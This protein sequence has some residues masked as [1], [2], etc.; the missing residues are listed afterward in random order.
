MPPSPTVELRGPFLVRSPSGEVRIGTLADLRTAMATTFRGQPVEIFELSSGRYIAATALREV[1]SSTIRRVSEAP[2]PAEPTPP[3][4][5]QAAPPARPAVPPA[6]AGRAPVGPANPPSRPAGSPGRSS[7]SSSGWPVLAAPP[8]DSWSVPIEVLPPAPARPGGA[9]AQ[10]GAETD[11]GAARR[12]SDAGGRG[13]AG[14]AARTGTGSDR[15][16]ATGS[17]RRTTAEAAGQSAGRDGGGTSS[18]RRTTAAREVSGPHPG[19]AQPTSAPVDRPAPLEP[20]RRAGLGPSDPLTSTTARARRPASESPGPSIVVGAGARPTGSTAR[21]TARPGDPATAPARPSVSGRASA[22]PQRPSSRLH[23]AWVRDLDPGGAA[24][25][26]ADDDDDAAPEGSRA[27][28][29]ITVL[30]IVLAVAGAVLF[31]ARQSGMFAPDMTATASPPRAA[32]TAPAPPPAPSAAAGGDATTTPAEAVQSVRP[33]TAVTAPSKQGLQLWLPFTT[34]GQ[35]GADSS[36]RRVR[37]KVGGAVTVVDDAQRHGVAQFDGR[38]DIAFANPVHGAFTIACWLRTTQDQVVPAADA[39][40]AGWYQGIGLIDGEVDGIVS[41]FGLSL[42]EGR[43]AFG[44]GAPDTTLLSRGPAERR[45]LAPRGR[46]ARRARDAH[47]LHRRPPRRFAPRR[48]RA[49]R[50]DQAPDH[51][52]HPDRLQPLHRQARRGAHLRPRPGRRRGG[53]AGRF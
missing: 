3:A 22:T 8:A 9:A 11:S 6:S 29:V 14:D 28:R 25:G 40:H 17:A 32:H 16:I 15:S 35:P 36:G 53:D 19:S 52:L 5:W 1:V 41:D 23:P 4:T 43:C 10:D 39:D 31:W 48:A 27:V 38:S 37:T 33:G 51:R 44:S 21:L 12:L 42:I 13:A 47:A 20:Y 49:A 18:A 45:H 26:A 46:G 7:E 34:G 2:P 50:R 24:S 30:G